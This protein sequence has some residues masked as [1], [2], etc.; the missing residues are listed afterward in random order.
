VFLSSHILAEVEHTC[1]HVAI[2]HR[3]RCVVTGTV[4]DVLASTGTGPAVLA[5]VADL[6]AAVEILRNAGIGAERR[7]DD[8]RVAVAPAEADRVTRVLAGHG[9]WVTELRPDARSLE[10]LFLELTDRADGRESQEELCA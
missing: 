8:V 5:R 9:Q 7:A 1:D 4:A 10:D 6:D 2:L 3:G